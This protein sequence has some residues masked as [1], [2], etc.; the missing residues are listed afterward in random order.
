MDLGPFGGL[1]RAPPAAISHSAGCPYGRACHCA[2]RSRNVGV[3]RS[4]SVSEYASLS[5]FGADDVRIYATR[6]VPPGE[7]H[8][9]QRAF[10]SGSDTGPDE[11]DYRPCSNR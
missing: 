2:L 9:S 1:F 5:S 11:A 7:Y 10:G 8:M 3:R 6:Y 4:A